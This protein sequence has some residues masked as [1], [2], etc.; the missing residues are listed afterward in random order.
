MIVNVVISEVDALKYVV[1]SEVEKHVRYGE[2]VGTTKCITLYPWCCTNLGRYNRVPLYIV[3]VSEQTAI[4][5]IYS[6]D[7]PIFIT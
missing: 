1:L 4:I 3:L 6:I 7:L 2:L 5:S